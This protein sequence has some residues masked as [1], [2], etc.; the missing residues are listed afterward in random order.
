MPRTQRSEV[1]HKDAS[2]F[3]CY[4]RFFQII[5]PS[6]KTR[7]WKELQA[8]TGTCLWEEEKVTES[9]LCVRHGAK[10]FYIHHTFVFITTQHWAFTNRRRS[11]DS[12]NWFSSHYQTKAEPD[13]VLL[14]RPF[15]F[16][17][18]HLGKSYIA[19][20][21]VKAFPNLPPTIHSGPYPARAA[22]IAPSSSRPLPLF[23]QQ[24]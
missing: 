4:E 22:L 7:S 8:P 17:P 14:Q 15:Y 13:S 12:V 23:A 20:H 2:D 5:E 9:L 19:L 6:T 24:F 16:T 21:E 10:G 3:I 18:F 11:P 1:K